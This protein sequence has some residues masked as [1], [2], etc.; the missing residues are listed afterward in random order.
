[1]KQRDRCNGRKESLG[2]ETDALDQDEHFDA[3]DLMLRPPVS[4]CVCGERVVHVV[5]K[6]MW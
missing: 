6:I 3:I 1:M 2:K 4:C 5:F